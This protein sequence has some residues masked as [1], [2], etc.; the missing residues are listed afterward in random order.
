MPDW[1]FKLI[2]GLIITKLTIENEHRTMNLNP[3]LLIAV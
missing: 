1:I 2:K 3:S